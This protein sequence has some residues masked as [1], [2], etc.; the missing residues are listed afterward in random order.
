[1]AVGVVFS[2]FF[3]FLFLFEKQ[4]A[5]NIMAWQQKLMCQ[6]RPLATLERERERE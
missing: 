5:I 2:F 3:S 1:V 4:G 6:L